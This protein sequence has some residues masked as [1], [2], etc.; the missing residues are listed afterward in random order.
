[1]LS[2]L[3][4]FAFVQVASTS[5]TQGAC[6]PYNFDEPFNRSKCIAHGCSVCERETEHSFN[7]TCYDSTRDTCCGQTPYPATLCRGGNGESCAFGSHE[8]RCCGPNNTKP[9]GWYEL[10]P[11]GFDYVQDGTCIP[12]DSTCCGNKNGWMPNMAFGCK[13]GTSCCAGGHQSICCDDATEVCVSGFKF[14]DEQ[15]KCVKKGVVV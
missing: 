4:L 5:P 3:G 1:M 14:K 13:K 7:P 9:C 11:K 12:K 2:I 8:S 15:P 10:E 6:R